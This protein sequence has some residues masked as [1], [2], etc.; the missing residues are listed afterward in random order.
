MT[1]RK[2]TRKLAPAKDWRNRDLS[3]WNV[4]SFT[5]YLRDKHKEMY[6][7]DYAPMG[8]G[9]G[10]EHGIL[11]DVIG[12]QSRTN[13]KPRGASNAA[14]KRFIDGTFAEYKP[15]AQYPGTSFGFMWVYRKNVWQQI[16]AEELARESREQAV[17][18]SPTLD[19]LTDWF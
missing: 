4:V 7:V 3:D 16:Q 18:E 9:W 15:T 17:E 1:K 13:P 2:A 19:E 10:R 12:T 14:V 5:E 8:G 11:R 6:G